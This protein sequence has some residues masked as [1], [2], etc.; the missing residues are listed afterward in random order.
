MSFVCFPKICLNNTSMITTVC[1]IRRFVATKTFCCS[2]LHD[3]HVVA[4]RFAP[5]DTSYNSEFVRQKC[6]NHPDHLARLWMPNRTCLRTNNLNEIVFHQK[7]HFS[8]KHSTPNDH[9]VNK[10]PADDGRGNKPVTIR[11][12]IEQIISD[13]VSCNKHKFTLTKNIGS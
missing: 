6:R 11:K 3:G 1:K 7:K 10:A 4:V 9:S 5:Q 2:S 8:T 12:S 13:L